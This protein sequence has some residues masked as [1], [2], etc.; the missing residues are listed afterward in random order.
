MRSQLRFWV[1]VH[2]VKTHAN[3]LTNG[4]FENTNNTFV[5]DANKTDEPLSG[6]AAIPG[7]T[8]SN[9]QLAWIENGN[10]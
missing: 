10:P 2:E 1:A 4:S 7:W 6:S 3:L 9:A 5:G 8:T